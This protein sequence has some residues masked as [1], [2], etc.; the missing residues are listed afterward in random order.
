M[1]ACA[2]DAGADFAAAGACGTTATGAVTAA[3]GDSMPG[4]SSSAEYS[5]TIFPPCH[6]N[7]ISRSRNGSATGRND[8]ALINGAP[9]GRRSMLSRKA[10]SEGLKVR[11][12]AWY[13]VGEAS[14]AFS[15]ASSSLVTLT[16]SISA[17]NGC[18]SWDSTFSLPKP[19]ASTKPEYGIAAIS[20]AAT[21]LLSL[22]S[23]TATP[24]GLE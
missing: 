4:G 18:P 7:S 22:N 11:L 12:A 21:H 24:L 1:G 16:R 15:V 3:A 6:D 9:S 8:V 14:A 10:F 23:R 19:A 5:R 17:E 2:T 13:A 20:P